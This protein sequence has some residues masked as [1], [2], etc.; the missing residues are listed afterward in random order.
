MLRDLSS[1]SAICIVRVVGGRGQVEPFET[2]SVVGFALIQS[3]VG[4]HILPLD[5]AITF[6]LHA[7]PS[8]FK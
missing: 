8:K 6:A 5:H 2:G 7:V 3:R 4:P 1:G